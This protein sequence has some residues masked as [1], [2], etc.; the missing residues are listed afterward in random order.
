MYDG[1]YSISRRDAVYYAW[2]GE[3]GARTSSVYEVFA[4]ADWLCNLRISPWMAISQITSPS[5][6]RD[7]E[8]TRSKGALYR[9]INFRSPFTKF[10]QA[11]A[12]RARSNVY[13]WSA[14]ENIFRNKTMKDI[15]P[16]L[17][18]SFEIWQ[19]LLKSPTS[20]SCPPISH[21]ARMLGLVTRVNEH[22][23]KV[24]NFLDCLLFLI[25][26]YFILLVFF[27]FIFGS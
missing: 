15:I 27:L 8:N 22:T 7:M 2:T 12:P 16:L 19:P 4:C 14:F 21:I 20:I 6:Q 18:A 17:N 9:I 26:F 11:L 25:S 10:T 13:A 24:S 5:E 3:T 23:F 1:F